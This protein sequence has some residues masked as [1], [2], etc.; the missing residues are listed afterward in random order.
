MRPG[1][2]ARSRVLVGVAL[3]C[4]LLSACGARSSP[5]AAA[6]A[7]PAPTTT[8]ASPTATSTTTTVVVVA[9]ALVDWG[10]TVANWDANHEADPLV[11]S[12]TGFWPRHGNGL[13]T[14]ADVVPTDGRILSFTM[15]L[16][17]AMSRAAALVRAEDE[18]PPETTVVASAELPPES[19]HPDCE[20]VLLTNPILSARLHLDV[21]IGLETNGE[22]LV[23]HDVTTVVFLPRATDSL[24]STCP[25]AHIGP[26][27]NG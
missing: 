17:P 19:A 2:A 4:G 25:V 16:Y 13:D 18:L 10:A 7:R 11:R 14:Y 9:P 1:T 5:R 26:Y 21:L 20:V 23:D 8:D 3:L 24:P 12:G 22:H 6:P 27:I 15:N